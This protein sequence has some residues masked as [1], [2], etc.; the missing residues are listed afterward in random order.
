MSYGARSQPSPPT[1]P[2]GFPDHPYKRMLPCHVPFN[3]NL[4]VSA[5]SHLRG[6]AM[7]H[8]GLTMRGICITGV[9]EYS[10]TQLP[11]VPPEKW[12]GPYL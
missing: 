9:L 11:T 2:G 12:H 7:L 10:V 6:P 8:L 4:R 1:W 3:A 5:V